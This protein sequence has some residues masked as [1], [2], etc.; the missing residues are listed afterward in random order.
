MGIVTSNQSFFAFSLRMLI[1]YRF[2]SQMITGKTF[3]FDGQVLVL[4]P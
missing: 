1:R 3:V 2:N 4:V